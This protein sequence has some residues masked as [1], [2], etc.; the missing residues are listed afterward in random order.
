MSRPSKN[1]IRAAIEKLKDNK[2]SPA[3]IEQPAAKLE[4]A[5]SN[6]QR[7]RKKGV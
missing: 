3:H 5:K 2:P 1:E 7:I 6:K 4:A